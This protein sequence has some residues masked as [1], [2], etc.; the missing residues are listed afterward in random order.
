MHGFADEKQHFIVET[1]AT[2][3]KSIDFRKSILGFALNRG[4]MRADCAARQPRVDLV[5]RAS[6]T[7]RA[8][9]NG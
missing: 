5:V 1:T 7:V 4:S 2:F 3:S 6:R 8:G 9:T